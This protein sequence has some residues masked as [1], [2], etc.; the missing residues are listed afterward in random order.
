M[1]RELP[2]EFRGLFPHELPFLEITF[3]SPLTGEGVAAHARD[4]TAGLRGV[5]MRAGLTLSSRSMLR[6]RAE[7]TVRIESTERE[8]VGRMEVELKAYLA[9][10]GAELVSEFG[11]GYARVDPNQAETESEMERPRG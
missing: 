10:R 4:V 5:A 11:V 3:R 7:C 8:A 2:F 9:E 6:N 1:R